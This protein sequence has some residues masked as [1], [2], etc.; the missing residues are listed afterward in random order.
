MKHRWQVLVW[1][2]LMAM[3][4]P[5]LSQVRHRSLDRAG[6][7]PVWST[8]LE[9]SPARAEVVGITIFVNHDPQQALEIHE[10][11]SG[12]GRVQFNP[13][14]I[15]SDGDVIG[16]AEA[17]RLAEKEM[18]R[19]KTLGQN[20]EL[21][22]QRVSPVTLLATTR[23]GVVQ[24]IDAETGRGMWTVGV[25]SPTR[26]TSVAG[27]N[28]TYVAVIN[29][30][31]LF[32]LKR[33]SG[34]IKFSRRLGVSPM[35]SLRSHWVGPSL[36]KEW[37]FVPTMA[38]RMEAHHLE[39]PER[40]S[41]TYFAGGDVFGSPTITSRYVAWTTTAGRLVVC[42]ALI[43]EV[44]FRLETESAIEGSA[45]YAAPARFFVASKNGYAYAIDANTE[46]LL[47]EVSLAQPIY[48]APVAFDDDVFLVTQDLN[49]L[50]LEAST[51]IT[52]WTIPGIKWF[53]AASKTRIY[54]ADQFGKIVVMNR[55]NGKKVAA[56]LSVGAIDLPVVNTE[57]D[58]IYVASRSG[59][60]EAFR[61]LGAELPL[62]HH[63]PEA[64]GKTPKTAPRK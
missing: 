25:G 41:W 30:S 37:V 58:R 31:T 52:R 35:T 28:D 16:P 2:A 34:E 19:R 48:Q 12:A 32:V 24:A 64:V 62:I 1:V 53:L 55:E 40:P 4:D 10:V 63:P 14:D 46:R 57:T 8:R 29:G 43:P 39:D 13:L 18:L 51:G 59:R 6:I 22:T 50:A 56:A 21:V 17:L 3:A 15:G 54:V 60:I 36:S 26:P 7:E 27:A 49:L 42:D 20:P 38:G 44:R 33:E 9:V 5:V 47:W 11:R 45:A 23:E 61:E